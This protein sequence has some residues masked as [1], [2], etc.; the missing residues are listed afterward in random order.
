MPDVTHEVLDRKYARQLA[1]CAKL[2]DPEM[3]HIKA[4][5]LLM[6]LL[7]ELNFP[8]VTQTYTKLRKDFWYA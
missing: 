3:I 1:E 2:D 8:R 6:A 5:E 7:T 4:D